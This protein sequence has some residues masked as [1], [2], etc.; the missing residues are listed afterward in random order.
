M[1][2]SSLYSQAL[3]PPSQPPWPM[4]APKPL[5]PPPR[6]ILS[7]TT[8]SLCRATFSKNCAQTKRITAQKPIHPTI[9]KHIIQILH[10][11]QKAQST[12]QLSQ[13]LPSHYSSESASN[14]ATSAS[15]KAPIS[16]D[17]SAKTASA[18]AR[19]FSL[20]SIILSSTVPL[21]TRR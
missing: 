14:L 16:S 6:P 5:G 10:P 11:T 12:H 1:L 13:L 9:Q 7:T 18:T 3:A 4:L 8:P 20:S 19:F 15:V 17:C 2:S 21:A